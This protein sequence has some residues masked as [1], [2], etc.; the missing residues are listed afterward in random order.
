MPDQAQT[1][2]ERVSRRCIEW[3][4]GSKILARVVA[5]ALEAPDTIT[6]PRESGQLADIVVAENLLK[7]KKRAGDRYDRCVWAVSCE[8]IWML[9]C[10][11]HALTMMHVEPI[12]PFG[13]DVRP[14]AR[15]QLRLM[16][17]P[18]WWYPFR[19]MGE[20]GDV[21]L[22]EP[23]PMPEGGA[24]WGGYSSDQDPPEYRAVGT[25]YVLGAGRRLRGDP[26]NE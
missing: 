10:N 20:R 4:P 8:A 5:E 3:I 21:A 23:S 22:F 6:Q 26:P 15:A 17:R 12:P 14:Y 16:G 11:G 19:P 25:V 24:V 2:N 18:V 7:L 9:V 1:W 13:E